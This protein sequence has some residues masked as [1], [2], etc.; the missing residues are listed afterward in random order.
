MVWGAILQPNV[1]VK[2][3][4]SCKYLPHT[5]EDK[6]YV[7]VSSRVHPGESN[8]SWLMHGFLNYILSNRPEAAVLRNLCGPDKHV[9]YISMGHPRTSPYHAIRVQHGNGTRPHAEPGWRDLYRCSLWHST[10]MKPN[11]SQRNTDV[12]VVY[13]GGTM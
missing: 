12:F 10:T 3:P 6:K 13:P 9:M 11:T 8:A 7:V 5:R 4:G 1:G 2:L